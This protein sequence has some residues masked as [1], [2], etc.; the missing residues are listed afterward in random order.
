ML[1]FIEGELKKIFKQHDANNDGLLCQAELKKAFRCIGSWI[2]G[3]RDSNGIHHADANKDGQIDD[4]ELN[5]L[6]EYALQLG[7]TV[8]A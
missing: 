1:N 5:K 4:Q 3:F 2:P 7:Y 6:V 8:K